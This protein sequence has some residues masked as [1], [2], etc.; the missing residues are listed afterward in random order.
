MRWGFSGSY[1]EVD[2][3]K[4][5]A[6]KFQKA[7]IEHYNH[8]AKIPPSALKKMMTEDRWLSAQEALKF[9]IVDE[10]I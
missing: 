2:P 10:V 9:G 1:N 3:W 5:S 6:D 8:F 7:L 4:D